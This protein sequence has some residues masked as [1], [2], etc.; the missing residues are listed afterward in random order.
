MKDIDQW[1]NEAIARHE[2]LSHYAEQLAAH[3]QALSLNDISDQCQ[4]MDELWREI[5]ETEEKLHQLLFFLGPDVLDHPLLG[6]YQQSLTA[7]ISS[8]DEG[9][10]KARASRTSLVDQYPALDE[11]HRV[12]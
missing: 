4:Q 11:Y 6:V 12:S 2:R 1:L 7:A 5:D 8:T 3:I 9:A 10:N